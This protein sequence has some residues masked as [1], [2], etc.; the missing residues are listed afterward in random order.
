MALVAKP[1]VVSFEGGPRNGRYT[2][3][4]YFPKITAPAIV[5][6]GVKFESGQINRTVYYSLIS[7]LPGHLIYRWVS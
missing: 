4:L 7:N 5:R 3:G 6:A 1:T 2:M